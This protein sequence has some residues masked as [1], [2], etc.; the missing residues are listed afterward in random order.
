MVAGCCYLPEVAAFVCEAFLCS[1]RVYIFLTFT[2]FHICCALQ[3]SP[4]MES[5][6]TLMFFFI[7]RSNYVKILMFS[8]RLTKKKMGQLS[9]ILIYFV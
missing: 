4:A 9:S 7:K 5:K 8:Q 2:M 3:K 6:D 1:V